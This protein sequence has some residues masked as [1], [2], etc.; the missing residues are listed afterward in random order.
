[1]NR[2]S[3]GFTLLECL[4]AL[5]I[6]AVALAAAGRATGLSTGAAEQVKLRVLAG[7]VAENRLSELA[8]QRAWLAP[9]LYQGTEQ[10][11]GIDFAWRMQ[12]TE[13]PHPRFRRIEVRVSPAGAPAQELRR[14]VGALPR[15]S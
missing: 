8:A 12:V 13:T 1:L 15:E 9:G 14:L 5:A 3:R 11:A 10:Q 2:T 7:V 6:V 4:V